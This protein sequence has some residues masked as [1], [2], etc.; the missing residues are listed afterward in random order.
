MT[1]SPV[2]LACTPITPLAIATGEH[3]PSEL[4]LAVNKASA[5]DCDPAFVP[6]AVGALF[7]TN[8]G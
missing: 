7:V 3:R 1:V 4:A 8:N 5:L 6:P 2:P